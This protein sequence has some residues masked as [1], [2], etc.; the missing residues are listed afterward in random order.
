MGLFWK[1]KTVLFHYDGVLVTR[2]YSYVTLGTSSNILIY[3]KPN[4]YLNNILK[5]FSYLTVKNASLLQAYNCYLFQVYTKTINTLWA[6][7][8]VFMLKQA[9]Q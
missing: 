7:C 9:M 5:F 2:T 4:M 3:F 6:T 1:A 8:K